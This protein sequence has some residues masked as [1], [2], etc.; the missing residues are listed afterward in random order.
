MLLVVAD[1]MVVVRSS[2][3]HRN[4]DDDMNLPEAV[5]VIIGGT[6]RRGRRSGKRSA[7]CAYSP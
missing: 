1:L 4:V 3:A 7:R 5:V 2:A 6:D